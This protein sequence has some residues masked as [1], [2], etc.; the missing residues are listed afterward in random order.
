M[1]CSFHPYSLR[2]VAGF[3]EAS[4]CDNI[5]TPK[6]DRMCIFICSRILNFCLISN[7]V[8][9]DRYLIKIWRRALFCFLVVL[10]L[11]C[12]ADFSLVSERRG[13]ALVVMLRLLM[14]VA[15]IVGLLGAQTS[16]VAAPG[17]SCSSACGIFPNQGSN[18]SPA[19][20][21]KFLTTEPPRKCPSIV[22]KSI[23][24]CCTPKV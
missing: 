10:G 23:K 17:P 24:R 3:S 19:L 15:S 11:H 12:C 4:C 13:Y 18:L 9:I 1:I 7:T 20:A 8:N 2:R 5:V 22:F 21:G 6:A 16:V 14:V